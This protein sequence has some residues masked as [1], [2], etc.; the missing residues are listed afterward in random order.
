MLRELHIKNIAVIEETSVE[1]NE[2]FQALTGETGAGKSI[3]IDSIGMALGGRTSREL[4]RTG[5]D[6]AAVDTAFEI[7][8]EETMK[9]L[10]ELGI[11]CEDGT[12]VISRKI[13]ADGKSRCHINGRLTPLNV[14]REAGALLLTIHGQNDNQSILSPKTHIKFV[15]EYGNNDALLEEY[16]KQFSAV[17]EI[18]TSLA[19]LESDEREKDKLI[20]LLT[21]QT[22]EIS[23]AKLKSG[24]EEELEERRSLL[25]NAEE[26]S[27]AAQGAYYA[28]Q[29]LDE[30][31]G[32]CDYVAEALRKLEAAKDFAP[33]LSEC[34]DT[35]SSVMADMDDAKHEL[36]VFADGV[37]YD[38]AE[39]DNIESRLSLIFNL[40]RKYGA[41]VDDILEYGEKSAERLAAIQKSDERRAELKA[42]LEEQL[43][44]LSEIAS[45][46]TSAR[47]EA[48]LKLQE[49]IMNELADLDM[50]KMRFSAEIGHLTEADGSTRYTA[51]G[52]DSVEFL[53]SANP[54]EALK[55][56]S[57]I[58]SGGEMSRIMLAIKSVLSD[59]DSVETMIFDEIDTGVSGRA[60]QKIAEKMGKLA[61]V[62]Q[63][64]C[65]TH[66]AQI[67]AMA[68]DQYL[69][70]KN[71]EGDKTSTTV[72]SVTGEARRVELARIIGGVK[73]T[74]LTLNAAQ[75]MLDMAEEYKRG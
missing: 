63:I 60:A 48:A 29:G 10:S 72:S 44:I 66:L 22:E 52:C 43:G 46:L 6:W 19:A 45:R 40:K 3:L 55:P 27:D 35:L 28:L 50:Q 7:D 53:I 57:K 13:Y 17:R 56:L 41:T 1:F 9:N 69:I 24:E 62:R 70:E 74:E 68:D 39:L 15:D 4:I 23:A 51:D 21:F 32:A 47:V 64:L 12:V 37:E 73:V 38:R 31:G 59:T 26:I 14:V 65:I 34:Y 67:A 25:Q 20:E 61:K 71:T 16:R 49:S 30:G 11:D 75:E 42:E 58:A 8:N 2:G 36:Y 33:K 18:K 5:A 54:G